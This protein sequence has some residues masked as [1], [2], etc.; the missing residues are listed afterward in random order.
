MEDSIVT[1]KNNHYSLSIRF[2]SDG[3]SLL[4][5]DELK[6][7]LTTKKIPVELNSISYEEIINLLLEDVETI[8]NIKNVRLIYESNHYAF[9]PASIFK[10]ENAAD[11]LF[12]HDKLNKNDS[13]CYN[14]IPGWDIVSVFAV[15]KALLEALTHLFPR[16]E[17][18]HHLSWFLTEKIKLNDESCIQIWLRP[19][20]MDIVVM[21]KGNIQM[22]N[23]YD[24]QTTEDFTYFTLNIFQQ[25]ALNKEEYKVKLYNSGNCPEL[26]LQLQKFLKSVSCEQ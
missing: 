10:V 17:L 22:I 5:F 25:L 19:K 24:Y 26:K 20:I 7:L 14:K 1:T 23:S 11:F 15:P 18:E 12:F 6:I 9:V 3:F 13:I 21:N 4:I 8:L 2:S 16:L